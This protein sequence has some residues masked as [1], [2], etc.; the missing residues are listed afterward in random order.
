[1][2]KPGNKVHNLQ[3]PVNALILVLSKPFSDT[4]EGNR[5]IISNE[6]LK[7]YPAA[8]VPQDEDIPVAGGVVSAS[9]FDPIAL[10]T[11]VSDVV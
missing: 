8:V 9:F 7:N 1:V 11:K 2:T 10:C 5:Y 4:C 6:V 3:P